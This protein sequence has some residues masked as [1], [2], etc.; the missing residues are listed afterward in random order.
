MQLTRLVFPTPLGPMMA[1]SEPCST[2]I[3]TFVKA[4][5]PPKRSETES[6]SRRAIG[7][8]RVRRCGAVVYIDSGRTCEPGPGRESSSQSRGT[9]WDA[10]PPLFPLE[11]RGTVG[12]PDA[13]RASAVAAGRSAR[14]DARCAETGRIRAGSRGG[15]GAD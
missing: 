13:I 3:E 14:P 5:T 9:Q 4:A 11:R 6:T 7:T 8:L 15:A 1:A 10:P 2:A 12:P